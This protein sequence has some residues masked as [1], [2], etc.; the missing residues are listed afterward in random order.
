M[1]YHLSVIVIYYPEKYLRKSRLA[2]AALPDKAQDVSLM[3]AETHIMQNLFSLAVP[4]MAASLLIIAVE[5]I[6]FKNY[7]VIHRYIL[8]ATVFRCCQPCAM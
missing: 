3:Y 4:T 1:M 5:V 6:Y 7:I 2:A 8:L